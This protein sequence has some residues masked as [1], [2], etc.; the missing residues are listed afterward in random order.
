MTSI[1]LFIFLNT[2]YLAH[3]QK[4]EWDFTI[5]TTNNDDVPAILTDSEGN[6]YTISTFLIR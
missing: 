2:I 1:F 6:V 5:G 4:H 3:S